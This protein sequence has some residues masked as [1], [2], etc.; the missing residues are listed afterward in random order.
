MRYSNIKE[1]ISGIFG[2]QPK[3]IITTFCGLQLSEKK[4]AGRSL[5]STREDLGF[6][7]SC[8]LVKSKM[9]WSRIQACV[10]ERLWLG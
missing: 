3:Y 5:T 6:A 2:Q 8:I 4:I 7:M 10:F 9:E 1:D